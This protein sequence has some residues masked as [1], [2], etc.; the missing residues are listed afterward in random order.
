MFSGE[1]EYIN[2]KLLPKIHGTVE[3][4]EP[5]DHFNF[6]TNVFAD[7]IWVNIFDIYISS[8]F[9]ENNGQC[10]KVNCFNHNINCDYD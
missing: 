10:S 6:E 5:F 2:N 9:Q 4:L 1:A 7:T 3:G 8:S